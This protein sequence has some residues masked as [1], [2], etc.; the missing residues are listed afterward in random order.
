MGS[1]EKN[2]SKFHSQFG[3]DRWIFEHVDLPDKGVFVDVGAGH[4]I[5]LSNTYFFE[6]NG[7]TGIC[8]DAD[9]AQCELL[10]KERANVEWTAIASTEGEIE[11]SQSYLPALS[12]TLGKNEHNEVM[13]SLFKDAIRV[14]SLKL[15]TL[16]AKYNIGAID[17]LDIDVEGT[18]LEVW[19]SFDYK[20]HKPKVLI[21][22]YYSLG[23][24]DNSVKV[25]DFFSNLP[26]RLVHT[27]CSNLIF[28]S[29]AANL[30]LGQSVPASSPL[31]SSSRSLLK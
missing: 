10:K 17:L 27:T 7:W 29:S 28:L 9:P 13:R 16:L 22:E 14:P 18:E 5:A 26:Y 19:K 24:S 15:E 30:Q 2:Y 23:L 8:V 6:Q 31:N 12:S 3:E 20:K 1:S 11:F 21:I 4:P 25:K